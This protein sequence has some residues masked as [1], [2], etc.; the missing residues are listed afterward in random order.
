MHA[1]SGITGLPDLFA[2]AH[3][4]FQGDLLALNPAVY[5]P[6][7]E[8]SG[9][10][11]DATSNARDSTTET[12]VDYRVAGPMNDYAINV[13]GGG[14][15]TRAVIG[16]A[17]NNL[18]FGGFVYCDIVGAGG[19]SC[20]YN[21]NGA[22][23]GAGLFLADTS[24]HFSYLCGGVAVGVNT[25]SIPAL[26]TWHFFVLRRDAGTWKMNYDGKVDSVNLGNTTP[27]A[28]VGSYQVST[29]A[30]DQIRVAHLFYFESVMTDLTIA[31][32][33]ARSL[34]I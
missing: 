16:A 18:T 31:E 7:Q 23:S 3:S 12:S 19:T 29:N 14:S 33:Y 11:I 28:P 20:L 27:N 4:T 24:R 34:R 8:A 10:L 6:C 15:I 9:H 21:G 22:S 30:S 17:V 32:L 1:I 2:R 26:K 25:P 13:R 5:W